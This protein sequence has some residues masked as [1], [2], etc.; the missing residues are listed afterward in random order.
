MKLSTLAVL[1]PS[2]ERSMSMLST[3]LE[4]KADLDART[5]TGVNVAFLARSPVS[6]CRID[7]GVPIE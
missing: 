2:I 4:L 5:S 7:S 3:L 6:W 1:H